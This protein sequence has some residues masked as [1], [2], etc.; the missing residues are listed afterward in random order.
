MTLPPLKHLGPLLVVWGAAM[1]ML[2][3]IRD[4]GSSLMFFGAFLALL[5][6]ATGRLFFVR[7]RARRCS[8]SAPGSSPALS[9]TSSD[10][11]DIW[12]DPWER[13][14]GQRL[15]DRAVA[16]RAG[17]RRA[18]REGLRRVAA[19]RFLDGE[20]DPACAATPT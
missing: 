15:P 4:L 16:V 2:I 8:S 11:I 18:L 19:Q 13:P 20:H 6:V 3:V 10:R 17:G 12:L 7:R 1:L 14:E 5:Y 9:R